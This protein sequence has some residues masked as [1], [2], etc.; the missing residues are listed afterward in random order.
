LIP[1]I[2]TAPRASRP[3]VVLALIALNTMVFLWMQS[4]P[5]GLSD[6]V[7]VHFALIPVRYS[8]PAFANYVGLDPSDGW[9]LLTSM[10]LH[11]GWLHLISNMWF[12]WIFG[13]A[14]EARF[15]RVGFIALYI[16]GGIIASAVHL[17]T[18]PGSTEPVLGASGAIAA[19]I[20]AY[21]VIYP[22]ER[23]WTLIPIGFFPLFV[24]IPSVLFGLGWFALQI[25]Q[26]TSELASAGHGGGIA[27]WAHI[28]GFAFGAFYALIASE[29][30]IGMQTRTRR[31]ASA[32]SWRVP[33]VRSRGF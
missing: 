24:P 15:G 17:V 12:L 18:H 14:M 19:V 20:A 22:R 29:L 33:N 13:A 30:G 5:P 1:L 31:W 3:V 28:G 7:V 10:F 9:P 21:T 6:S 8:S 25:L 23:V 11:G 16:F 2:D 4:L 27:W 26:G 32:P